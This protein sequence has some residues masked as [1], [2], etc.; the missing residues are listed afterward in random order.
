[1]AKNKF[2]TLLIIIFILFSVSGCG[3][4]GSNLSRF[5]NTPISPDKPVPNH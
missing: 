4:G 2:F 3:G 5:S 1:M